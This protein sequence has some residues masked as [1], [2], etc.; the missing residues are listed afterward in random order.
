MLQLAYTEKKKSAAGPSSGP[1]A[2]LLTNNVLLHEFVSRSLSGPSAALKK[3]SLNPQL[4]ILQ[5][6]LSNG[7]LI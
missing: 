7:M 5:Q 4:S 2:G 1:S 6:K 3:K